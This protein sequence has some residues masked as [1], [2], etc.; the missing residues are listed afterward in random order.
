MSAIKGKEEEEEEGKV[1]AFGVAQNGTLNCCP[2]RRHLAY[3]TYTHS[4]FKFQ[5]ISGQIKIPR[6]STV[7][8]SGA[9]TIVSDKRQRE[10]REMRQCARLNLLSFSFSPY[11]LTTN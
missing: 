9:L 5:H 10:T 3:G 1:S 6:E 2:C 8:A 4:Q 7:M 11:K